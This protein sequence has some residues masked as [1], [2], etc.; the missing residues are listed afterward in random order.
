MMA[1]MGLFPIRGVPDHRRN[2]C[3]T[4]GE[5]FQNEPELQE[6]IFAST[7]GKFVISGIICNKSKLMKQEIL[8]SSENLQE[9]K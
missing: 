5:I 3:R 8:R 6:T 9:N 1:K 4:T 7:K 2:K